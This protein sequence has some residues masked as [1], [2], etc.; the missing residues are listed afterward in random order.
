MTAKRAKPVRVQR[1]DATVRSLEDY[2][3]RFECQY[4]RTS[5]SMAEAV[6]LNRMEETPE[7][8]RWLIRY[9]VLT[10]LRTPATHVAGSLGTATTTS[11]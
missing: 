4:G 10:H 6:A 2:V 7:I 11:T 5:R 1:V 3:R 9:R 8:A